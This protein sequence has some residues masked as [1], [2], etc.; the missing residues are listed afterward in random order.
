MIL[1]ITYDCIYYILINRYTLKIVKEYF[2]KDKF[3]GVCSLFYWEPCLRLLLH[4]VQWNCRSPIVQFSDHWNFDISRCIFGI[5]KGW[6]HDGLLRINR[7]WNGNSVW[8]TIWPC[9]FWS[10]WL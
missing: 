6:C 8:C 9:Y 4:I 2:F 7:S 5:E 1:H 10:I 3:H